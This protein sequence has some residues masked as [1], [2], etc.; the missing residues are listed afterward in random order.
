MSLFLIRERFEIGT[1]DY[2]LQRL[3]PL[4]HWMLDIKIYVM[5]WSMFMWHLFCCPNITISP[6]VSTVLQPNINPFSKLRS[7]SSCAGAWIFSAWRKSLSVSGLSMCID[8]EYPLETTTL[9]GEWTRNSSKPYRNTC[10]ALHLW[11]P[12]DSQCFPFAL[13]RLSGAAEHVKLLHELR[14]AHGHFIP[15]AAQGRLQPAQND[16]S[17]LV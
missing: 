1:R 16:E 12:S 11:T 3:W 9:L 5:L 13:P 7:L 14:V 10:Q 4:S 17:C 8:Q 15:L 6:A 2:G